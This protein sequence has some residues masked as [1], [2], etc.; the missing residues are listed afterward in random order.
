MSTHFSFRQFTIHH[1]RCAMKTGTDGVLLGAWARGGERIADIGSGSGLI[2]LM[3]AQRFPDAQ[4]DGIEIDH[5]A[6]VQSL[7]NVARSP[8]AGR[9]RIVEGAFQEVFDGGTLKADHRPL[10]HDRW[11][12]AAPCYDA[13]VSNPPYF[14]SGLHA[15]DEQRRMARHASAS[16]FHDF[17]TFA[18]R[19]LREEGEVS[20]V[21]PTAS[22]DPIATEAYL[23]GYRLARLLRLR[24]TSRKPHERCLVAFARRLTTVAEVGEATLLDADGSRSHWYAQLTSDFYL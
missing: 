23:R 19:W 8:F 7:E 21:L 6:A 16:F 1:D 11:P 13:I 18:R 10:A 5:E 20:L 15:P 9:V 24:T 17:F 3:L 22:L 4:I 2:S 12:L 14:L